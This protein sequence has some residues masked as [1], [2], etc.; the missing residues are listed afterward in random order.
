MYVIIIRSVLP[1]DMCLLLMQHAVALGCFATL[2]STFLTS[3]DTHSDILFMQPVIVIACVLFAFCHY[4]CVFFRF[5]FPSVSF[6]VS[7]CSWLSC[8]GY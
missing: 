2:G 8:C 5:C 1:P 4:E 7:A 6:S 3:Y